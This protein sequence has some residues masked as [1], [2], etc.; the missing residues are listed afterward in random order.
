MNKGFKLLF[1]VFLLLL[2]L[3]TYLEASEPDP[4]NWNPSY[5]ETD[6]I[7]LGSY[8]F[9][10]A[11]Q[12]SRKDSIIKVK[13]PPFEFLNKKPKGTYFFVNNYLNFD[14][15]ELEKLLN[16]VYEGNILFLSSGWYSENILDT[17][18]LET[19]IKVPGK[20]FSSQPLLTLVNPKIAPSQPY[21][22]EHESSLVYLKK[23]DT[24]KHTILGVSNLDNLSTKNEGKVNFISTA[25]GKGK[26][27]IHTMP[28]AFSN[29]FMLSNTNYTYAQS[30]VSYLDQDKP[31]YWDAYYK[32]GKSFFTSPLHVLFSK[33]SLKWAYY[34][35]LIGVVLFIIF[36]GKR[37]QR[38]IP[39]VSPL[40]NQSYEYS[41]TISQLYLEQKDY[42][43]LA[44]KKIEHFYDYIRSKYRVDT[45]QS[46]QNLQ[47]DFALKANKEL[48]EISILLAKLGKY[49][50][51]NNITKK[52]LEELHELI[53]TFK[54]YKS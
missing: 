27:Y 53:L 29:Y 8:V 45:S 34:F 22:Y 26:I 31:L 37:K 24:L 38:A 16:W 25:F 28:E 52:E 15:S 41:K 54:K 20:D 7:A 51:K 10:E 14:D 44:D 33:R 39:I 11:W 48:D 42:K 40:K 49:S 6:K 32:T 18:K 5:L 9:Y 50:E 1:A 23:I 21:K 43:T 36:E 2:L 17:L 19:A 12:K 13:I 4:V 30:V 47:E 46:N 3:L 35:I